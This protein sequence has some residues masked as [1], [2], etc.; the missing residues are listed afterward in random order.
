MHKNI[1]TEERQDIIKCVKLK[2]QVRIAMAKDTF[3]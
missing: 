2:F 1:Y 3:I